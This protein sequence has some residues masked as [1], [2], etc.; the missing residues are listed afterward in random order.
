LCADCACN[1]QKSRLL[2]IVAVSAFHLTSVA[3]V[4]TV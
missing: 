2:L 4:N 3:I 1:A